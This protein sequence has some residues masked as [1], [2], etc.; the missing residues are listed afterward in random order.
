LVICNRKEKQA[1]NER[2]AISN[3]IGIILISCCFAGTN[4][5][6]YPYPHTDAYSNTNTHS[7]TNAHSNT[8]A[9]TH[10]YSSSYINN[11][12]HAPR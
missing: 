4:P 2:E 8:D 7:N 3:R 1:S 5:H 9:D 12:K 10:A 6:A 11:Y